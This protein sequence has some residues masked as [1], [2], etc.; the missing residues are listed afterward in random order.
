M[1]DK[2]ILARL[3]ADLVSSYVGNRTLSDTEFDNALERLPA[4]I[5]RV[6]EALLK[7]VIETPDGELGAA[8]DASA[9]PPAHRVSEPA[10]RE[11]VFADHLVCLEDG[12]PFKTLKRHLAVHHGMT[13]EEYRRKWALPDD[14]PMAAPDYAASR[15]AIAKKIGLGASGRGGKP[16]IMLPKRGRGR[17]GRST[18]S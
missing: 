15:A 16:A 9:L 18:S 7:I 14:Y 13:P 17:G 6:H 12:L 4:L 8:G 2:T 3:T 5:G 11:T 1:T 10:R